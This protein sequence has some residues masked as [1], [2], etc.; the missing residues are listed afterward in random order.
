MNKTRTLILAPPRTGSTSLFKQMVK[1]QA[2][3]GIFNPLDENNKKE[4]PWDCD[5]PIVVKQNIVY[6]GNLSTLERVD[7]YIDFASK[8]DVVRYITREDLQAQAE[9]FAFM[10]KHNDYWHFQENREGFTS[11]DKYIY[12]PEKVTKDE[13]DWAIYLMQDLDQVIRRVC[14]RLKGTI[15]VYEELFDIWGPGRYRQIKEEGRL[16]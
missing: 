12:N 6:P 16:L 4:I 3:L 10:N 7:Y 11:A 15:E 8:F 9:S 14:A 2:A 5:L 13:L 1:E